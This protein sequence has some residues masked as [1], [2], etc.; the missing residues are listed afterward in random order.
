[1]KWLFFVF[2][3]VFA[4]C[5]T[6]SNPVDDQDDIPAVEDPATDT[7]DTDADDP[8]VDEPDPWQDDPR[9]TMVDSASTKWLRK[10][11]TSRAVVFNIADGDPIAAYC[12]DP[13][14]AY[15]FYDDQA[16]IGYE[17]FPDAVDVMH[18]A[19]A[20]TV[21][22]HNRDY[23]DAEWGYINVPMPA[24]PP[25]VTDF[26]PVLGKWQCALVL[27]GGTVVEFYQA[28]YDFEWSA[29]KGGTMALQLEQYNRD[30][31][32][33]AFFTAYIVTPSKRRMIRS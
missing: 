23:P 2:A 31:D 33:D 24:P 9:L 30:H 4:S 13:G 11:S 16:V 27:D 25:P 26:D 18:R 3:L 32:P 29:W 22:V 28:E 17:P 20:I 5:T 12:T 15:M 10:P 1:M 6:P 8:A 7:P 21:E 19:V 14:W